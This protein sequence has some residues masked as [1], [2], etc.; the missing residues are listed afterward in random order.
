[1]ARTNVPYSSLLPNSDV[2]DPAGTATNAGVGNGHVIAKAH[3]E[4][5]LLRVVAGS[6]G[7]NVT[8]KA[9]ANPPA[10]AAGQGDL[11]IAVANNATRWIGP[12]ESG[13]FIQADGSLLVDIAVGFVAGTITAFKIPR[14]T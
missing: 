4:L 11:V 10:I 6:T 12:L 13:R 3:P 8:I 1:M 14:N 9:G 2:A 5:T 7:G